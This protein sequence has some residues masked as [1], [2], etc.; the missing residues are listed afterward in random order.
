MNTG[1]LSSSCATVQIIYMVGVC[2]GIFSAAWR[3]PVAKVNE[4]VSQLPCLLFRESS[5]AA[6]SVNTIHFV[7]KPRHRLVE[8]STCNLSP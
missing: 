7:L 8:I 4:G 3:M 6:I 5:H 2:N 1:D